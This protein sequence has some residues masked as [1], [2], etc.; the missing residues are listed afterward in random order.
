MFYNKKH[1]GRVLS[2]MMQHGNAE[3]K[4]C[5][6]S[7]NFTFVVSSLQAVILCLFNKYNT[8]TVP[9]ISEITKIGAEQLR[10]QLMYLFGPKVVVLKKPS[11]GPKVKDDEPI[12]VNLEVNA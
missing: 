6:T 1:T 12:E 11:K 8:M 2:W 3:V 9:Q 4:S 10:H 5:W 7:K